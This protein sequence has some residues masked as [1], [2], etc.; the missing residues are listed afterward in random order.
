MVPLWLGRVYFASKCIRGL[1]GKEDP[2]DDDNNGGCCLI[3][4]VILFGVFIVYNMIKG[5][6][7]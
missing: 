1:F 6:G 4:G 2:D 3:L 7:E 5:C